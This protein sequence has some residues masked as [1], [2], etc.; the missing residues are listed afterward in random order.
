MLLV[1]TKVRMNIENVLEESLGRTLEK[2]WCRGEVIKGG[3]AKHVAKITKIFCILHVQS[4]T[5]IFHLAGQ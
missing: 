3:C 2:W 4:N 5:T 1:S